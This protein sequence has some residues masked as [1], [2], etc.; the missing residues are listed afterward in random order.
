MITDVSYVCIFCRQILF[1]ENEEEKRCEHHPE[2]PIECVHT[3][4]LEENE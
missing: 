4:E 2:A 1:K 3:Y